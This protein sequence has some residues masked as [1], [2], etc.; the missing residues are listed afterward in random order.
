MNT[1]TTTETYSTTDIQ[2]VVRRFQADLKMIADSTGAIS[3]E[4]VAN[5]VHDIEL[6]AKKGYLASVDVTLL[7]F[8]TEVC[9]ARYTVDTDAGG[10]VSSRPGNV[11]WPRVTSP[12][13]RIVVYYTSTYDPDARQAMGSKLHFT[14]STNYDDTSHASLNDGGGRNYTSGSYGL[15]RKDWTK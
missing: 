1:T 12:T 13:L 5:Y 15:K 6:L 9:A 11:M 4:D 14:W 7:D 3:S 10:L 2:N 8:A